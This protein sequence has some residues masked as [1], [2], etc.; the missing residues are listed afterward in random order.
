MSQVN[1][2][3]KNGK[4]QKNGHKTEEWS[5]ISGRIRVT[6]DKLEL[7][8]VSGLDEL[9]RKMEKVVKNVRAVGVVA[10]ELEKKS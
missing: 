6:L 4:P 10:K 3:K 2:K 7:E 8:T 1:G 5:D 9:S